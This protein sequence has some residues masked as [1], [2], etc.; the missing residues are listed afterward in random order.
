LHG[1]D[2]EVEEDTIN[3]KRGA[4]PICPKTV[5][6]R[7]YEGN[8]IAKGRQSLGCDRQRGAV[9]VQTDEVQSGQF[10]EESFGVA[11]RAKGGVDEDGAGTVGGASGESGLQQFDA[12]GE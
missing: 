4:I 8:S 6:S 2:A 9:S 1:R 11:A 10:G 3:G 12:A 7:L 5:V